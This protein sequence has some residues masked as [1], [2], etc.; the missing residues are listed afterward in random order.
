ML[1]FRGT[2]SILGHGTR[3]PHALVGQKTKQKTLILTNLGHL[4]GLPFPFLYDEVFE[5][6]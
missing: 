4:L 3:I 2:G 1:Q 5:L 6:V